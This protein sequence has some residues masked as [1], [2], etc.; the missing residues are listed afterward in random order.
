MISIINYG[1]GNIFAFA[2]I[3]KDLN[4]NYKIVTNYKD[5][6]G[7]DKIILPGVG[8]F[9]WAINYLNESGMR[10]TLDEL[11]LEKKKDVLGVC[12]GTQMMLENSEEGK[13]NGLG[14]IK[15]SVKKFKQ[16]IDKSLVPHIGWNTVKIESCNKLFLGIKNPQFYF[17]HSYFIAPFYS[18]NII[19]KTDYNGTF[20]SVIQKENI[21][22]TQF[23]PEK[24]HSWGI[25][26]LENFANI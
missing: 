18:N 24:S 7:T 19:G 5:L 22:G 11:V 1:L 17:L 8:A 26:L 10:E 21:Y 25:K 12:V 3:L 4:Y 20:V 16:N 9:D 23:H 6:Q 2:N 14:W 15:G 13:L